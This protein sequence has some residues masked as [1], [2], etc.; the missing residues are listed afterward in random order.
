[1]PTVV[2]V[3][4]ERGFLPT[5]LWDCWLELRG[6]PNTAIRTA[7]ACFVLFSEGF[8]S[9]GGLEQDPIILPHR[10][11]CTAS[12]SLSPLPLEN[13][14][15]SIV[16]PMRNGNCNFPSFNVAPESR[17]MVLVKKPSLLVI[18]AKPR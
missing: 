10:G 6:F 12:M 8:S 16:P 5:A 1:V 11:F 15:L 7:K 2:R 9:C 3:R 4:G 14:G 18:S 13:I 17:A